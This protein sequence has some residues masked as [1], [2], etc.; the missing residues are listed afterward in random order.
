MSRKIVFFLIAVTLVVILSVGCI[1]QSPEGNESVETAP[2][3]NITMTV[4]FGPVPV[5]SANGV[6]I[7]YELELNVT[8]NTTLVPEKL[9][10]IDADTG[11][12]VYTPSA[13]LLAESFLVAHAPIPADELENGS[14]EPIVPRISV[15]FVV[16]TSSVPD[17]LIHRLTLNRTA[18]GLS[19]LTVTGGEVTVRKDLAPVIV[20]SPLKGAGWTAMETTAPDTHHFLAPITANGVTRVPQR[21]AQDFFLVDPATGQ[22]VSGNATLSKDYYGYGKEVYAVKNGTVAAVYDGVP[23][24][25][26]VYEQESLSFET[27][28]GNY[29]IIDIGDKKYACYGHFIPGSIRVKAGDTVTEGEVIGLVGNS[30]NSDIPHL[31]VQVVTGT[32]SLLGAEGY[33]HVYRSF[34]VIG[35]V[36]QSRADRTVESEGLSMDRLWAEFGNFVEFNTDPVPQE[37]RLME[38]WAVVSFP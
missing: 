8:G 20:G 11:N 33:P 32:P 36:N 12:I 17:R 31:H 28:A 4:P 6:N 26:V 21:Y 14:L 35:Q 29:V 23:D 25:P 19:P 27:L 18:E 30:G 7:A 24:N 15:W 2:A 10:V 13:D 16:N 5:E 1:Q 34:S 9:E 37:N 38:N 3:E 22:A